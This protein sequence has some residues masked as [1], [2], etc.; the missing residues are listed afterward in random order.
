M[1]IFYRYD[2]D[3]EDD[4]GLDFGDLL[5]KTLVLVK[6]R[7]FLADFVQ[8]KETDRVNKYAEPQ[9]KVPTTPNNIEPFTYPAQDLTPPAQFYTVRGTVQEDTP[10]VRIHASRIGEVSA[11]EVS[12][13]ADDCMLISDSAENFYEDLGTLFTDL[14]PGDEKVE[15]IHIDSG[16]VAE[17]IDNTI[18]FGRYSQRPD[19]SS[20]STSRKFL[21]SS[22]AGIGA[23]KKSGITPGEGFAGFD[24]MI[25]GRGEIKSE[26]HG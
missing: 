10:V 16:I 26:D 17:S 3:L 4:D 11:G 2:I 24:G 23:K 13:G 18:S 5:E 22:E 15:Q 6:R 7:K 21:S 9:E 12:S 8:D 20:K 1:E 14:K 19:T 25:V